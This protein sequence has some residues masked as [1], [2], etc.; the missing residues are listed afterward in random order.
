MH[1]ENGGM[2]RPDGKCSQTKALGIQAVAVLA[3]DGVERTQEACEQGRSTVLLIHNDVYFEV[4]GRKQRNTGKKSGFMCLQ[5]GVG[6]AFHVSLLFS[7][8]CPGW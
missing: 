6:C 1:G 4:L 5:D 8:P 2:W 7:T 3:R